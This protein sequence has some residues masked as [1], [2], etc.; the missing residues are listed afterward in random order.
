MSNWGELFGDLKKKKHFP[1]DSDYVDHI[2][3][4]V[5][6]NVFQKNKLSCTE[7]IWVRNFAEQFKKQAKALWVK[8]NNQ[9]VPGRGGCDAFLTK[10]ID[11]VIEECQCNA[12]NAMEVD[13]PPEVNPSLEIFHISYCT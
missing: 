12:C 11:I 3:L 5:Q 10:T 2:I 8:N 4:W 13:N 9:I 1:K 6:K 7:K